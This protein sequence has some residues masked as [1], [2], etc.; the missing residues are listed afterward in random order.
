MNAPLRT[1]H[2]LHDR[3]RQFSAADKSMIKRLHGFMP[4]QQLLDLLNERLEADRGPEEVKHTMEQLFA[5]I[6][7]VADEVPA[8]GHD[9]SS[10]RKL[11]AG[12]RKKG[13]LD[14]VSS[15]LIDDFAVV[16]SLSPGQVLRLQDVLLRAK[17]D[18]S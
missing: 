17:E 18:E 2:L 4:A 16:Y 9:W 13:L 11:L 8:D 12:A 14:Q 15:Q 1:V 10:L 6:G 5:E 7:E 3:P